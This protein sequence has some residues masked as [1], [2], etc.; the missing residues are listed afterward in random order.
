M[1]QDA[2]ESVTLRNDFYRDNYR[3]ALITLLVMV[4]SNVLL[5]GVIFYFY[6]PI[7]PPLFIFPL[8]QMEK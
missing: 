8:A 2:Q 1:K 5:I 7:N 4:L 3:R 6:F